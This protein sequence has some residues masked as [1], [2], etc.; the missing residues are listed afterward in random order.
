MNRR[1][2]ARS[3]VVTALLA[4]VGSAGCIG[5]SDPA[6]ARVDGLRRAVPSKESIQ[7]RLPGAE[8][9]EGSASDGLGSAEQALVG[10]K[11]KLYVMTRDISQAVN[12]A[13]WAWLG[14]IE[15]IAAQPPTQASDDKAVWGPHT[16]A[17]S[18]VTYVFVVEKTGD[19]SYQYALEGKVKNQGDDAYVPIVY[20]TSQPG[21]STNGSGTMVLDF[22]ARHGLDPT[23]PEQGTIGFAYGD[24]GT[25]WVLDMAFDGFVDGDG[26]GPYDALYHYREHADQSG[27]FAFF[28]Q[29]DIDD[30]GSALETWLMRSRWL[31]GGS[32][33][34]DVQIAGG[35]LG[36]VTVVASECWDEMFARTYWAVD[37]GYLDPPEGSPDACVFA[38]ADPDA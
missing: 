20:G 7:I 31:G 1:T 11:A 8:P 4:V 2:V 21:D 38:F 35:D 23:L 18:L 5:S 30:N 28:T 12:T 14:L 3:F 36:A 10:E 33:R 16:P 34:S 24:A 6:E 13:A 29:S 32:G 17:L 15:D 22:G 26:Q 9:A 25:Q 27:D 37:P 19:D